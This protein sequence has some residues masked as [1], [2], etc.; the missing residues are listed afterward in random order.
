VKALRLLGRDLAVYRGEDGKAVALEAYCA[1]MGA[2]LAEGRVEGNALR[3]FFHHWRYDAEGRCSDIPCLPGAPPERIRI[4]CFPVCERYGMLWVWAGDAPLHA[5]PEPPELAGLEIDALLANRFAKNCHPS[6][7]LVNAIDEQHF[8]SVHNL[9]G[10]IL[11][12]E[13]VPNG[14]H[15]IQFRNT[16]RVPRTH[17]LGRL[18][19]SFYRN[20]LTYHLSYWYGS[21]GTVTFGPDF[22]HLHLMFA[23]R[24]GDD[25]RTEGQTIVLTRRRRGPLGWIANRAILLFTAIAARYFAYGDTRVFQ[26][27]RFDFRHPIAADRTVIAFIRHL[28]QQ[29]PADWSEPSKAPQPSPVRPVAQLRR[30]GQE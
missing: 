21:L 15:N 1:H 3:C 10:S 24:Q 2:H 19:G 25:G 18:L 20:V 11:S 28:E 9:P 5:V 14:V 22:L 16:G 13:P 29:P 17:W 7:V 30:A 8:R 26:T 27:I 4:R 23:L 12:M 6:V